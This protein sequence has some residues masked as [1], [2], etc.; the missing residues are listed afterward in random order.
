[1]IDALETFLGARRKAK[2]EQVLKRLQD[3]VDKLED[4]VLPVPKVRLASAR[5][6]NR[7]LSGIA[8]LNSRARVSSSSIRL[9]S[10]VQVASPTVYA[11]V[12]DGG[13]DTALRVATAA[14]AATA[15]ADKPVDAAAATASEEE[16]GEDEGQHA[17]LVYVG[18]T[19][20]PYERKR[21]HDGLKAAPQTTA[22][23]RVVSRRGCRF[24]T[25]LDAS[26]Q[27]VAGIT[28]AQVA[29]VFPAWEIML[30]GNPPCLLAFA[31]HALALAAEQW[32]LQQWAPTLGRLSTPLPVAAVLTN[33][34]LDAVSAPRRPAWW[35]EPM[36]G[37]Q[38]TK[39]KP[40]GKTFAAG[41][42]L[43][44]A[45][46]AARR[47]L[48]TLFHSCFLRQA[49]LPAFFQ[50]DRRVGGGGNLLIPQYHEPDAAGPRTVPCSDHVGRRRFG[51][52]L[53]C[54]L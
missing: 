10:P 27:E 32:L 17:R 51:R 6:T 34:C 48:N 22:A 43:N 12:S 37:S 30:R 40:A 5:H 4:L 52:R 29:A 21:V 54:Q 36:P 33:N 1:M 31:Q 39:V 42:F 50:C 13:D 2:L 16:D 15:G 20:D 7:Y 44:W 24:A 3:P 35:D 38:L 11:L 9:G 46:G 49:V 8:L 28:M 19:I 26:P 45:P 41:F 25:L 47:D 53:G 23:S 14:A 18:S